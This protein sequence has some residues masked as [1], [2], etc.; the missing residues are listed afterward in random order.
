MLSD[1]SLSSLGL[2]AIV[3]VVYSLLFN[4]RNLAQVRAS[5][6]LSQTVEEQQ[7]EI[8][9]ITQQRDD[10]IARADQAEENLQEVFQRNQYTGYYTGSGQ[11]IVYQG[12]CN[13]AYITVSQDYSLF[14]VQD[15]NLA[16]FTIKSREGTINFRYYGTLSGN[17]FTVSDAEDL[18]GN[19]LQSC[20]DEGSFVIE[21]HDDYLMI[22]G[23]RLQRVE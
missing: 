17:Q 4:S 20:G 16:I 10:A 7:E 13:G 15:S 12:E 8:A 1:L 21:F 6:Q 11:G 18:G 14:F 9:E 23:D 2:F 5:E 22:D 19:R 3:F